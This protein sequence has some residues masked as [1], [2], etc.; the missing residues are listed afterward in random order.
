M[1]TSDP[2]IF[3]YP[4]TPP[5]GRFFAKHG[6]Y[7]E[8]ESPISDVVDVIARIDGLVRLGDV[9]SGSPLTD[10]SWVA[11][12][13]LGLAFAV[14]RNVRAKSSVELWQFSDADADGRRTEVGVH[15]AGVASF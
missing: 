11:R 5:N 7:A 15:L 6:A 9:A 13:T 8:L 10:H 1:D 2:T 14:L 4:L 12:E 3:K